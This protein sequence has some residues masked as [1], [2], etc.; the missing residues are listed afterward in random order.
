M[1]IQSI[2]FYLVHQ[3]DLE[4]ERPPCKEGRGS[5]NIPTIKRNTYIPFDFVI[6]VYFKM[7]VYF[8]CFCFVFAE[9]KKNDLRQ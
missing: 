6:L 8:A 9:R 5:G 1:I 3:T 4:K 7:L 2:P